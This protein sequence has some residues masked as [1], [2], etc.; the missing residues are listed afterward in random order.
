MSEKPIERVGLPLKLPAVLWR[1]EGEREGCSI[2]MA[3]EYLMIYRVP[4]FLVV[5]WFGSFPTPS[6]PPF[7]VNKIDW[8]HKGRLRKKDNLQTGEGGGVG[9]IN[10]WCN[11]II[12]LFLSDDVLWRKW[13]SHCNRNI[14]IFTE[15]CFL[16]NF[17]KRNRS[18][19]FKSRETFT[20][21]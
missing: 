2:A 15:R 17:V 5:V 10:I 12:A 7:P 16:R 9:E 8:Q 20:F 19:V 3:R 13:R 4:G 1:G 18:Q 6:P 14:F 21:P 11:E